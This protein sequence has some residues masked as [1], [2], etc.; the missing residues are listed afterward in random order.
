MIHLKLAMKSI[1]NRATSAL[2]TVLSIS[3]SVILLLSV[4]RSRRAAEDGF[5]NSIS[6]VDLLVGG[7]TGPLNLI[8][9]TVFNMGNPSN[10]VTWESYQEIKNLPEIEWTIP[11]SLGDSHKG[12]RVVATDKNFYEHYQFRGDGRIELSE[13]LPA[14]GLWDVVIG[15][16][17]QKRLGYKLGQN[18]VIAHGVTRGEAVVFHEDKPFKVVGI[19]NPTGTA[20]DES[21]YISLQGMEAIHIDWNSGSAPTQKNSVDPEKIDVD[22]LKIRAITSFFV[23]TKS[24]I[25]TLKLQRDINEYDKEPLLAIIPGATLSELWRGLSQIGVV[26]KIISLMVMVV[27]LAS[28]VSSLLS[29]LNERRREMAILR[30]VGA[31]PGD[32]SILLVLES[33]VLTA[34][35]ILM[36][37]LTQLITFFLLRDWIE[38]QYGFYLRG[39]SISMTEITYLVLALIGGS[40]MGF[41]PAIQSSRMALKDGLTIKV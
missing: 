9:Y 17:V 29:S 33:S 18:V 30:S 13:G 23:R 31:S 35:G 39:T 32:I 25:Q 7:R 36:G 24:R 40:L 2:L 21:I 19:L 15:S 28:M 5:T 10:N 20:V 3:L 26:L 14:V 38:A 11:Y 12:F 6:K 34:M 41:I 1:R 37:L 16:E 27:G 8:L 4:E 22:S